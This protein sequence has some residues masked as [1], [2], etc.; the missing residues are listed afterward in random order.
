MFYIIY[1]IFS[2]NVGTEELG[3]GPEDLDP[4]P[5]INGGSKNRVYDAG[6][7]VR[8]CLEVKHVSVDIIICFHRDF[9]TRIC[10]SVDTIIRLHKDL[11]VRIPLQCY[12]NRKSKFRG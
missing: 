8:A 9:N 1:T 5:I 6:P 10:V 4:D 11:S 12:I 3:Y 7:K 2:L